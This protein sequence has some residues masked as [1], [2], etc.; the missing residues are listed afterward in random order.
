[1]TDLDDYPVVP[2]VTKEYLNPRQLLD[3]RAEREDCLRWL[4]VYGKEPEQAVDYA[5]GTVNRVVT[6]WT[7]LPVRLGVRR[8]LYDQRHPRPRQRLDGL[9]RRAR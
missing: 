2:D 8:W 5:P 6:G 7:G 3:Y 9:P 1:M 4:L